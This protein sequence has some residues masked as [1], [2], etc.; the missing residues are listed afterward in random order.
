MIMP[1]RHDAAIGSFSP[2]V[3]PEHREIVE[4]LNAAL[5][6]RVQFK[7]RMQVLWR[8]I[9]G[10]HSSMDI[11]ELQELVQKVSEDLRV[12]VSNF[13]DME[14]N[15]ELY[16]FNGDG[17]LQFKEG[18]R[19]IKQGLE[20][21]RKALGAHPLISVP[22]KTPGQAGYSIVTMLG[23]GGQGSVMLA[24]DS[25]GH[26]RVLKV[27]EKSNS[28]AASIDELREEMEMMKKATH[29]PN[30]AICYEIFQDS[31]C[32]YMV[33]DP[34][35][36]GDFEKIQQNASRQGVELT[37]EWYKAIFYQAFCGLQFLHEHC[38][39]HCDIKE[40]NIMVKNTDYEHPAIVIIDLGLASATL[41]AN[42]ICG[43]P[44]Y[45]PPETWDHGVW[46][47]KGDVFSMGV[48]VLQM[49]SGKIPSAEERR[50][51]IFQ[52][53]GSLESIQYNTRNSA[54]PF[55]DMDPYF[56]DIFEWL[57]GAL[58][59]DLQDRLKPAEVL[60]SEW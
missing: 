1:P 59:K 6:S 50:L 30:V 55:E 22:N 4:S 13:G 39:L 26:E 33:G 8:R 56:E 7:L 47:P 37:E 25:N 48:V 31:T 46:Y 32:F 38:V 53:G 14:S 18:Y 23:E 11:D 51:G 16:D 2:Q 12:P 28:N 49:L 15:I 44:G 9:A 34:Y 54:P 58:E 5:A 27:Y 3:R 52:H 17:A 35:M 57:P 10:I 24:T 41:Q 45:M 40:P 36:G 60:A 21:Y 19:M 29:S 42:K 43:T 20:N